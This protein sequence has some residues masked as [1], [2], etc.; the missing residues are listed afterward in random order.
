[1]DGRASNTLVR[2]TSGGLQVNVARSVPAGTYLV[3]IIAHKD[4]R[5]FDFSV[6]LGFQPAPPSEPVPEEPEFEI[7]SSQVLEAVGYGR[8][9]V[10][11]LI[12]SGQSRG[13]QVGFRG[14]LVDAGETIGSIVI[15][16]VF[17]DGSRAKIE[18]A[19]ASP[20]THATIAEI[21][22]PAGLGLGDA[23]EGAPAEETEDNPFGFPEEV[24]PD[25]D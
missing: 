19:L 21:Q 8:D 7:H 25:R 5:A 23:Q 16:Q 13:M 10:A 1:M 2:E 15:E 11:V 9:T 3:G 24:D 17:P 6:R 22:V 20:V 4:G 14:R 18:G 12:E